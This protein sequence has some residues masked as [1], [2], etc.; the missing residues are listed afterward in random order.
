MAEERK[1]SRWLA[2]L[3]TLRD[4]V[5]PNRRTVIGSDNSVRNGPENSTGTAKL[6]TRGRSPVVAS[7][8]GNANQLVTPAQT[9]AK[10]DAS[11]TGSVGTDAVNDDD[12]QLAD[13]AP[14]PSRPTCRERAI[15]SLKAHNSEVFKKLTSMETKLKARQEDFTLKEPTDLMTLLE[16]K[17]RKAGG[18]PL[19]SQSVI[20]SILALKDVFAVAAAFDPHKVAPVA[21]RGFCVILEVRHGLS[22][23]TLSV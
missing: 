19:W 20:R 16:N 22:R 10:S 17:K 11:L 21:W 14:E 18:L 9:P 3:K 7:A 6:P 4:K 15:E 23:W 2:R 1:P 8:Q 13:D 5:T 12:P